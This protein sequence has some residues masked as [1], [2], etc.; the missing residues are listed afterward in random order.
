MSR[1]F[2][3]IF[4]MMIVQ[5]SA[6]ESQWQLNHQLY[7][8]FFIA[9]DDSSDFNFMFD[10]NKSAES[11]MI[12][13]PFNINTASSD[14]WSTLLETRAS[15]LLEG[16]E[17]LLAEA[18]CVRVKDQ[19]PFYSLSHFVN[20][21]LEYKDRPG[22]IQDALEAIERVQE[23]VLSPQNITQAQV[24]GCIEPIL[25]VRDDTFV[26]KASGACYHPMTGEVEARAFCEALVQRMP[27]L[28]DEQHPE[29]G[30]QFKIVRFRWLDEG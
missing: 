15:H 11:V 21:S 29:K 6:I 18:I 9:S 17:R 22:I 26:I 3:F 4:I 27:A 25:T 5:V 14:D 24:L 2:V 13:R 8:N 28:V 30:R 12:L 7:D 1:L 23:A 19:G 16:K 20:G 10:S